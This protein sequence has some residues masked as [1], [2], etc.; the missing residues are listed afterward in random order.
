MGDSER[1][2]PVIARIANLPDAIHNGKAWGGGTVV[3]WLPISVAEYSHTGYAFKL[4]HSGEVIVIYPFIL[5][6]SVDYEE[7]CMMTL[8]CGN[9]SKYPCPVCLVPL[10]RLQDLLE[11]YIPWITEEMRDLYNLAEEEGEDVLDKS[12]LR[13]VENVFWSIAQKHLERIPGV[14][15]HAAKVVIDEL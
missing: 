13:P 15:K 2:Y 11:V 8:I 4:P 10:A 3:G 1:G 6:L 5:I 7:Q 9:K 12:S 14:D